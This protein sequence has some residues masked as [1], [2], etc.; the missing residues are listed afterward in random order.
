[1]QIDR[2]YLEQ[3]LSAL[4]RINSVNPK[5]SDGSTDELAIATHLD[6]VMRALGMEVTL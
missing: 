2:A 4:V 5:F 1:M 6:G 3:T